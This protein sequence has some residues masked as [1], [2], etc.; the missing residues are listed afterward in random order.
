MKRPVK[1]PVSRPKKKKV[2]KPELDAQLD[3]NLRDLIKDLVGLLRPAPYSNPKNPSGFKTI[4]QYTPAELD[5]AVKEAEESTI[6]R[7]G[8]Y[9]LLR[10]IDAYMERRRRQKGHP[11]LKILEE[12]IKRVERH[13]GIVRG[14][15]SL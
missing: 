7:R 6:G 13:C 8:F 10:G 3:G 4:D 9:I 1:R 12:R 11:E 2:V 5:S 14:W 15:Q